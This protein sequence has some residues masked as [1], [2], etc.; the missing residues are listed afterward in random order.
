M[1]DSEFKH[2]IHNSRSGTNATGAETPQ[3]LRQVLLK[4]IFTAASHEDTRVANRKKMYAMWKE[5]E[6]MEAGR[7]IGMDAS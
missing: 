4:D 6:E 5:A 2:L 7:D 1:S 3:E